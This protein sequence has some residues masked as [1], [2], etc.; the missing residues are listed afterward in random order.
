M[1]ALSF[2]ILGALVGAFIFGGLG[3]WHARRSQAHHLSVMN[4]KDRTARESKR[5]TVEAL[6]AAHADKVEG[7]QELFDRRVDGLW[8]ELEKACEV[9]EGHAWGYDMA[10]ASIEAHEKTIKA[11][12]NELTE[13]KRQIMGLHFD[14]EGMQDTI[15]GLRVRVADLAP[16]AVKRETWKRARRADRRAL[17]ALARDVVN[18]TE[19]DQKIAGLQAEAFDTSARLA[20][21][22]E[23]LDGARSL[24]EVASVD[25]GRALESIELPFLEHAQEV[26]DEISSL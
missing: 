4:D 26:F 17:S 5:L 1:V 20:A 9:S 13:R 3:V 19:R 10:C 12:E 22:T 15:K 18:V 14:C 25:V 11:L 2:I 8:R 24:A 21:V 6:N 7:L 16:R 23:A